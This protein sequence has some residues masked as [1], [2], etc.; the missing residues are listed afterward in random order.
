VRSRGFGTGSTLPRVGNWGATWMKK[1]A[2]P[3]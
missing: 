3:V 2:A 1:V